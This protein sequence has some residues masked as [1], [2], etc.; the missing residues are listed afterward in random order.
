M[1]LLK[2]WDP[3]SLRRIQGHG[4][5][6]LHTILSLLTRFL[7]MN[8]THQFAKVPLHPIANICQFHLCALPLRSLSAR[9]VIAGPFSYLRV[10]GFNPTPHAFF[11]AEV[12]L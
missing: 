9:E 10:V 7:Q 5:L 4:K 1:L 12:L 2:A 6:Q 3:M 11:S 8:V